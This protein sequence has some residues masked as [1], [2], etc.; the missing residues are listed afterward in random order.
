MKCKKQQIF[1]DLRKTE[2]EKDRRS[3]SLG[4]GFSLIETIVAIAILSIV[5]VAPLTLA[6]RGI[7]ASMYAKDQ[8][9]AF[10]LA[11]EAIEYAR[12]IRDS[13]NLKDRS[14]GNRWLEG[15][16]NCI[17]PKK[18]SVDVTAVTTPNF[19]DCS[20]NQSLCNVTFNRDIGVYGSQTGGAW[21]STNFVRSFQIVRTPIGSNPDAEAD[22]VAT[23]SWL[24]GTI[25]RTITLEEKMFN[26]FPPPAI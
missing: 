19:T 10:Y 21:R 15:L 8:V 7:N 2:E 9:T 17:S 26:W 5:M 22:L 11:Q 16:E 1:S 20:S 25:S 24:T 13:N 18:C 6:Q 4:G 14:G 23:V 12:Y 3:F